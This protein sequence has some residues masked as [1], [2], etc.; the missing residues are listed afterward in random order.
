MR[1][2]DTSAA[3]NRRSHNV[4][5]IMLD[6]LIAAHDAVA[7]A[8]LRHLTALLFRLACK[9]ER[10]AYRQKSQ[11]EENQKWEESV[12]ANAYAYF[13]ELDRRMLNANII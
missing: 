13:D 3:K 6:M 5:H 2:A 9:A 10:H 1:S 8:R 11:S 12:D 7:K 4:R